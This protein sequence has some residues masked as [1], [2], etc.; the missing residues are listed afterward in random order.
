M[1][2]NRVEN[3]IESMQLKKLEQT[4]YDM[5]FSEVSNKECVK[6]KVFGE[7][8][9]IRT[10]KINKKLGLRKVAVVA[11]AA[12]SICGVMQTAIAKEMVQKVIKTFTMEHIIV[13]QEEEME[14]TEMPVPD[15]LKG[16]IYT[17]EG[18]KITVFTK[19]MTSFYTAEGEE[20]EDMDAKTGKITT[21]KEAQ[22]IASE[23]KLVEYDVSK[24]GEYIC[25]EAKL[26]SYLPEGYTFDRAEFYKDEEGKVKNSKYIDLY[27]KEKV[28]GN[29]LFIQERFADEET[30]YEIGTDGKI[31]EIELNGIKA[32]LMDDKHLDWEAEG[33]LFSFSSHH[34]V[35]REELIKI[36][37]SIK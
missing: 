19:D 29:E 12:I 37:E 20:I 1:R 27:F 26:P 5:D 2:N 7:Y 11:V 31:E 17:V 21:K 6:E 25:F 3:E 18:E 24:L 35:S 22:L 9:E 8:K 13:N 14:W 28:T 10:M 4:L 32:I 15:S 34:N 36:A 33:I 16:K 30:A 23:Q